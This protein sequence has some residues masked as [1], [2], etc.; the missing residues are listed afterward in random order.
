MEEFQ[1]IVLA[2]NTNES[3]SQ[4]SKRLSQFWTEILRRHPDQFEAVFAES[5]QFGTRDSRPTRQ[6]VVDPSVVP[7]LEAKLRETGIDLLPIDPDATYNRHEAVAPDW[8]QIHH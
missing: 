3:E 4:F 7:L 8:W 2:G 1:A 6:Y 5:S